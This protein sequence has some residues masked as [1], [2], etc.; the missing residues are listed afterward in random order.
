MPRALQTINK[1]LTQLYAPPMHIAHPEKT[2]QKTHDVISSSL[3]SSCLVPFA[4]PFSTPSPV[5]IPLL[6]SPLLTVEHPS[7]ERTGSTRKVSHDGPRTIP[8]RLL[9]S[10]ALSPP[11]ASMSSQSS[12]QS[13]SV[14]RN[15]DGPLPSPLPLNMTPRMPQTAVTHTAVRSHVLRPPSHSWKHQFDICKN[16]CWVSSEGKAFRAGGALVFN[17][18]RGRGGGRWIRRLESRTTLPESYRKQSLY[19]KT[20]RERPFYS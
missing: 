15:L 1:S 8:T 18:A 6:T 5:T 12:S 4:I 9:E 17:P 2:S 20:L 11:L 3:P 10:T 7:S 14:P 16:S 19:S 13:S